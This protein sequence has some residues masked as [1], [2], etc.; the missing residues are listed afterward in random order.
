MLGLGSD[1]FALH[2]T[3]RP[4][5]DSLSENA[6][7]IYL[8]HY[9]FITWLEY[10]LLAVALFAIAK[11]A[12]VFTGTLILSWATCIAMC[13]VPIGER[14]VGANRRSLARRAGK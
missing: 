13:R 7:G 12:I 10:I 8:V 4:V 14:L 6:Y 11:A 9:L 5:I 2:A 1:I 3:R